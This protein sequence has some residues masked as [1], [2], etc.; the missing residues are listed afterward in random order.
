MPPKPLDFLQT[1]APD[2]T[3]V[4]NN[5]D[6]LIYQ[7]N[8]ENLWQKALN[9]VEQ[10]MSGYNHPQ[11]ITGTA[12]D[13]ALNPL[14]AAKK[15]PSLMKLLDKVKLRN[16]IYHH[17]AINQAKEILKT[18]KIKPTSPFKSKD[19][20][21]LDYD[22]AFSITRDPMF[23]SRPHSKIGT[24]VRFIMDRDDLIRKGYKINPT[25]ISGFKKTKKIEGNWKFPN[26][27]KIF[28][29]GEPKT[30]EW[31]EK[32]KIE[33][34]RQGKNWEKELKNTGLKLEYHPNKMNPRFEF[35]ER[36]LGDLPTKDIKLIDIANF[37][38]GAGSRFKS[39]ELMEQLI[40]SNIPIIR[41]PQTTEQMINIEKM[42]N[43]YGYHSHTTEN[44]NVLDN[45]YK[46]LKTPTYKYNPFKF[47]VI[48]PGDPKV[49]LKKFKEYQKMVEKTNPPKKKYWL[50]GGLPEK[51]FKKA[52]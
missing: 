17:T 39:A 21:K 20:D 24:D 4:H 1:A 50:L 18:G 22:K 7:S 8:A 25:A 13:V 52:K 51:G 30:A 29:K 47:D 3:G 31:L 10:S 11:P 41:S 36:V 23:L 26:I 16:P 2:A 43:K 15:I 49:Q 35:E 40:K 19:Y 45:L 46:L 33:L 42:F 28:Y 14:L 44:K 27:K 34:T 5:I 38:S 12:P 6:D 9:K 37:P 32:R 48:W